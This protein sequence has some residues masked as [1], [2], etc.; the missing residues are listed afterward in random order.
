[1]QDLCM[2]PLSKTSFSGSLRQDPVVGLRKV[3]KISL[4]ESCKGTCARSVYEI[5]CLVQDVCVKI[6]S[7]WTN[8]ARSGAGASL[9]GSSAG[10]KLR[11]PWNVARP[12]PTSPGIVFLFN[13]Q[14]RVERAELRR[15]PR[16]GFTPNHPRVLV[17]GLGRV[18]NFTRNE[19]RY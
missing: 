9:R 10:R 13:F 6:S 3:F 12:H 19:I 7:V 1:M 11:G 18:L 2:G 5:K 14:R 8:S 4:E 17:R 15:V 16:G